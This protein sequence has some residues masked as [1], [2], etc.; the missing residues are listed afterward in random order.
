M[1]NQKRKIQQDSQYII[2]KDINLIIKQAKLKEAE[3]EIKA[4]VEAKVI[5]E[6]IILVMIIKKIFYQVVEEIMLEVKV[7]KNWKK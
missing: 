7:W 6:V 5:V 4:E 3:A 1:K 2:L